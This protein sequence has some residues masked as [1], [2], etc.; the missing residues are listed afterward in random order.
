MVVLI[1]KN[2][3]YDNINYGLSDFHNFIRENCT[4]CTRLSKKGW[5]ALTGEKQI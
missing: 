4:N 5:R 3:L 2:S 1:S